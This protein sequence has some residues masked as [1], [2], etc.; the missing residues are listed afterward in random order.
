MTKLTDGKTEMSRSHLHLNLEIMSM[1]KEERMMNL[2][3]DAVHPDQTVI[4]K[5]GAC[6][7]KRKNQN[8]LKNVFVLLDPAVEEVLNFI[9][10]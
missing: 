5:S 8:Q 10:F 3:D 4:H 9:K 6:L 7:Q 1:K 2:E